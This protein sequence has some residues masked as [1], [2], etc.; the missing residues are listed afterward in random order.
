MSLMKYWET[1]Q[2]TT[3]ADIEKS[4]RLDDIVLLWVVNDYHFERINSA[5]QEFNS[6]RILFEIDCIKM[7][8]RV[9]ELFLYRLSMGNG[10]VVYSDTKVNDPGGDVPEPGKVG[11]KTWEIAC[12]IR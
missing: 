11:Y 3:Y 7:K 10:Q 5:G 12:T 9:L 2:F 4:K 6:D 8:R 1:D